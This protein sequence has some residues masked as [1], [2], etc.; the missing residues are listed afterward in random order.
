MS[1][2]QTGLIDET[3]P[4]KLSGASPETSCNE[5]E[6]PPVLNQVAADG[7]PPYAGPVVIFFLWVGFVIAFIGSRGLWNPDE[8]RYLQVAWEM[9]VSK[10]FFVPTFNG[11][12]YAQKPPLIF[13]LA[14][15]L[16]HVMPFEYTT[17]AV[18]AL[19][20]LGTLF[21][22]YGIGSRLSG[23][24]VGFCAALVLMSAGLYAWMIHTGNIDT[25]LTFFTT[26][27]IYCILKFRVNGR[28]AWWYAACVACGMGVL[29]KGPVGFV[30]PMLF[31]ICLKG[32]DR[33]NPV[34]L[35]WSGLFTGIGIAFIPVLLWL[36]PAC[37]IGGREYTQLILFKQN[38]GR[39]VA[40]FAHKKPWYYFIEQL[41]ALFLPWSILL[42]AG[43][44]KIFR[45]V[46]EGNK[47]VRVYLVWFVSVFLFFSLMSGKRGRYLLPLFPAI[48]LLAAHVAE[49]L[50]RDGKRS[51]SLAIMAGLS[52]LVIL[53]IF[54]F[55]VVVVLFPE[56][57]W[58]FSL[59]QIDFSSRPLQMMYIFGIAGIAC[60]WLAM[61]YRREGRARFSVQA[62]ALSLLFV[63]GAVHVFY[64]PAI[65]QVKSVKSA[66]R[67]VA[68]L[69]P[70]DGR[71]AF[72]PSR[73]NNGWNFYLK[74]PHIPVLSHKDLANAAA[75]WDVVIA[76]KRNVKDVT[77]LPGYRPAVKL[78]AGGD[79]FYFFVPAG[80]HP[81]PGTLTPPPVN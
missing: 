40:S 48:S 36:V 81:V 9:A 8:P 12:I 65:D 71:V 13:W 56:K 41:P 51:I 73:Y 44:P 28:P 62:I 7:L 18:S 74:K 21:L 39:A 42:L 20:G 25:L 80:R 46:R 57:H 24:A 11:V 67:V 59:F 55:P 16:S 43:I 77:A 50:G 17:Q 79:F 52:G 58:V 32:V 38:F 47:S 53:L 10:H 37:I 54:I 49:R 5:K 27:A 6:S 72:Y 30:L 33:K 68:S 23:R 29:A 3:P 78:R 31:F 60:I 76:E 64:L 75:A 22:T 45:S 14:I 1:D 35:S 69:L 66:S 26:L 61:R 70:P 4:E 2:H 63:M 15:L 34:R 19:S